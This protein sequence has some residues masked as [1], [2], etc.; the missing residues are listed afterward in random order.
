MPG[1]DKPFS[2]VRLSELERKALLKVISMQADAS[3]QASKRCDTR[4][5]LPNG[6]SVVGEMEQ[7]GGTPQKFVVSVRDISRGGIS[8]LYSAY[9]HLNSR[10]VFRFY[11]EKKKQMAA[12]YAKVVRCQHVKGQIHD[13][14]LK[15]DMPF[16][17]ESFLVE[18]TTS[19]GGP[20][21]KP[22][23]YPALQA[24]V[25]EL[26]GLVRSGADL[27]LI[28]GLLEEIR[29]AIDEAV[30][31]RPAEPKATEAK[32][33]VAKPAEVKPADAK[34]TE[35][36]PVAAQPA[37]TPAAAATPAPAVKAA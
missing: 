10:C 3:P 25:D 28:S 34:Q 14:G 20:H 6:Y 27:K 26:Q 8:M 16:P 19:A 17:V 33:A 32:P 22:A 29:Q 30:K 37:A 2:S 1:S 18:A 21:N 11:D 4:Y 23:T 13:V 12:A 36:K 15:F 31:T 24:F 5:S 7:S 9:V 35:A